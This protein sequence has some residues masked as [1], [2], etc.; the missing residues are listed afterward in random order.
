MNQL[1]PQSAPAT[2]PSDQDEPV[3]LDSLG[4]LLLR[5]C[6][7]CGCNFALP[8]AVWLDRLHGEGSIFCPAGHAIEIKKTPGN[9]ADCAI[10]A[11]TLLHRLNQSGHELRQARNA[12]AR[13]SPSNVLPVDE[14]EYQRRLNLMISRAQHAEY[15]KSICILCGKKQ[16]SNSSFRTH[17]KARHADEL[18]T[19]PPACFD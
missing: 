4:K 8:M 14:K 18:R 6:P 17:L 2:D 15:G 16:S 11:A 10:L 1:P 5:T 19:L 13:L 12:L 7:T 9:Q 3:T